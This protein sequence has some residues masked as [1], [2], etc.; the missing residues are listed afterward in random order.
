MR[1]QRSSALAVYVAVC[2]LSALAFLTPAVSPANAQETAPTRAETGIY[3][4]LSGLG[5]E[6]ED[7]DHSNWIDVR[8]LAW[9]KVDNP[10][11]TTGAA[12]RCSGFR[13]GSA[14]VGDVTLTRFSDASSSRLALACSEGR[15]FPSM[16]VE[17]TD[18]RS[19]GGRYIRYELQNV[20]MTSYSLATTGVR[21]TESFSFNY[22]KAESRAIP[23]TQRGKLDSAWDVEDSEP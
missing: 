1:G 11:A 21:P 12:R 23:A 22:A 2:V 17:M 18:S 15:H 9:G 4:N 3:L 5:G 19:A 20:M 7:A 10:A 8:S 16:V 6:L 13:D 14:V